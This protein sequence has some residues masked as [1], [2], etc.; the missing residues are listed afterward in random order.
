[1][2]G[3]KQG[4]L[5]AAKTN[6]AK[7]GDDFYA[8]IGGKGGTKGHTGGFWYAKYVKKDEYFAREAGKKGGKISRRGKKVK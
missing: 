4:G 6:K 8:K 2:S 5:N 1:M 3:T 7:Y